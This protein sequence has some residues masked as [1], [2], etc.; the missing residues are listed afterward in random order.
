VADVNL[1]LTPAPGMPP[2]TTETAGTG[3]TA[4]TTAAQGTSGVLPSLAADQA[5]EADIAQTGQQAAA[6]QAVGA[7][8]NQEAE[9]KAKA[10]DAEAA[11]QAAAADEAARVRDSYLA[12][13]QRANSTADAEEAKLRDFKFHDYWSTQSTGAHLMARIAQAFGGYAA[14]MLG[15]P[16]V[17]LQIIQ[18]RIDR[19]FENQKLQLA[20]REK[21]ASMRRAG[22][23]DLYGAMQHD[24]AALEVK[25]SLAYKAVAAKAQAEALRNG[26][27][28]QVAQNNVL[29]QGLLAKGTEKKVAAT[30]R[31]EQQFHNDETKAAQRTTHQETQVT[32]AKAGQGGGVEAD[33]NAANFAVLKDHG[34]WIANEMPKLSPDDVK[35]I[36]EVMATEDFL[37]GD[38]AVR[39]AVNAVAAKLGVDPETGVSSTAKEYLDRVRRAAEGLGRV[40]SGAAIGSVENKRFVASLMPSASDQPADLQKRAERIT[41]DINSRGAFME[42]AP[43]NAAGTGAAADPKAALKARILQTSRWIQEHKGDP[44]VDAARRAISNMNMQLGAP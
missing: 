31:Y 25:Q 29:V 28:V 5:I 33:K 40:Q 32:S 12:R 7:G 3:T 39:S 21:I 27:P 13:V 17:A 44:R 10:L 9:G 2:V 23:T 14:G 42:R 35:A 41:A 15:G 8:I 30:Q 24:L 26:A 6:Q 43:R 20:S 1:N 18:S 4:G 34:T 38:G 11:Q 37:Q 36:R 22:V 19:D 16:N